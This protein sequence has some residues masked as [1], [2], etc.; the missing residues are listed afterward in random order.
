MYQ[1]IYSVYSR[2][3]HD[4]YIFVFVAFSHD[5][6]RLM[7]QRSR[8]DPKHPIHDWHNLTSLPATTANPRLDTLVIP[9]SI[10]MSTPEQLTPFGH[11]LAGA[12]GGV[13]SN[14]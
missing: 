9:P 13:F 3:V 6:Y 12:L 10:T 5:Q 1:R 11:A 4:K 2:L 8:A 7:R 14:A